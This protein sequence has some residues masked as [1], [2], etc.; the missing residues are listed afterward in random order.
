MAGLFGQNP[1]DMLA[2]QQAA[3]EA[4]AVS[5]AGWSPEQWAGYAQAKGGQ[6]AGRGVRGL[7]G[8]E[9][10]MLKELAVGKAMM[11]GVDLNDPA[12]LENLAKAYAEKGLH[13]FGE[14]AYNR[15]QTLKER[16]ATLAEQVAKADKA[17]LSLA[18]E[19]KL[20][21]ELAALGPNATEEQYLNVVRKYGKPDEVMKS[22]ETR[23]QKQAALEEKKRAAEEA[24]AARLEIAKAQNASR[25]E[26]ARIMMEGRK[27]LAALAATLK[28][29]TAESK[30]LSASLQKSEDADLE[31]INSLDAQSTVLNPAIQSLTPDPKTGKPPLELGMA[32]NMLYQAANATGKSTPASRAYANLERSVQA[33][34]NLKVSAEKGVQTDKD[35]LRFAN[36]LIAAFGKNDTQTTLE[37]L[38]NFNNAIKTAKEKTKQVL[39]SRRKSQKVEPYQFEEDVKAPEQQATPKPTKRFNPATGKVEPI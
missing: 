30:P 20:R 19:Q 6:M 14:E 26:I 21:D 9:D 2:A 27:E 17:K 38:T 34:T 3:D 15:A 37:A 5:K 28:Q 22:I 16:N 35:V 24:L 32:N 39:Q 36:E 12:A 11:E 10:P 7:L 13:R 18:Q 23:L 8:I 1:N 4:S 31:K 33:A 29:N 25:E